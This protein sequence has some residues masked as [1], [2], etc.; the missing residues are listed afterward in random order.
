MCSGCGRGKELIPFP[1]FFMSFPK[2]SEKRWEVW[3]KTLEGFMQNV[4]RF[5][6]KLQ[7]VF[8]ACRERKK[9]KRHVDAALNV[10]TT[11]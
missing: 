6:Q 2:L 7:R 8:K 11:E 5:L 1:V 9:R 4:G 3:G 10:F